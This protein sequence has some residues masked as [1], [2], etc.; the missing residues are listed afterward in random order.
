MSDT[1]QPVEF[2]M[3]VLCYQ[4]GQDIVPFVENLHRIMSMFRFHWELVLVAN[5]WPGRDD[6]T[7][8]IVRGLAERLPGTRYVAEPKQGAMG[9]DMRRGLEACRGKYIGIIDGDGQFP[10]EA[11]FSCFATI[12]SQ[13]LDFVKTYR[14][15]RADGLYRN[16]ISTVYNLLFVMLFPSYRGFYDVNSKPK[17]MKREAFARMDLQSTDW[18]IDAEIMINCLALGLRMY[19]IPI[20]FQSLGGRKSFVK[21]GAVFEFLRN[22]IR[23][24]FG[25][26]YR[27]PARRG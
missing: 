16:V 27:R 8:E 10:V 9:W 22:L 17:I 5:Y 21:P 18:F 14:V 19:E 24:R 15:A 1:E 23:H 11:I 4:A 13:D 26:R 12:K 25:P 20:K 2:S 3:A 7:P 6:P